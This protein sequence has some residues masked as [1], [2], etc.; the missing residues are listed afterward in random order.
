M[1]FRV[2]HPAVI[3]GGVRLQPDLLAGLLRWL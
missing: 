1:A 3:I 2:L